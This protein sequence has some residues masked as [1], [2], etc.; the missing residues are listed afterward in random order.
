VRWKSHA[1]SQGATEQTAP[2]KHPLRGRKQ[3][4]PLI[5]GYSCRGIDA[6]KQNYRL[7]VLPMRKIRMVCRRN[8]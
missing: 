5:V 6:G 2:K 4:V 7:R 3:V 8:L 1:A